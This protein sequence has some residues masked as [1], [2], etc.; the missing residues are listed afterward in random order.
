MTTGSADGEVTSLDG[1]AAAVSLSN[2]FDI[3]SIIVSCENF[4]Y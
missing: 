1:F 4:Y 3:F 2:E